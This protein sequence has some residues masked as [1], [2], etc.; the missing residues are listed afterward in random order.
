[1]RNRLRAGGNRPLDALLPGLARL[2]RDHV[3]DPARRYARW[4]AGKGELARLDDRMLR[5]I[6]LTRA[7]VRAAANGLIRLGEDSP[8]DAI[9]TSP[10]ERGDGAT[11]LRSPSAAHGWTPLRRRIDSEEHL[12]AHAYRMAP[13]DAGAAHA[14]V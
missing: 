10:S 8:V 12:H 11:P 9:C 3:I 14:V 4:R 13:Q 5:D 1:M 7:Q 2:A 6:G